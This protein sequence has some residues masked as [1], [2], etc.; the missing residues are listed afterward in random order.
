MALIN[1]GEEKKANELFPNSPELFNDQ[2]IVKV[3][4]KNKQYDK[5]IAIYKELLLKN[6]EDM[7]TRSYLVATYMANNQNWLALQELRII[8][9]KSPQ[10]KDQIDALIKE[11]EEG[12]NPFN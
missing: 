2:K 5:V 9:E 3:Y 1:N 4:V 7:Q 10:I 12:R 8:K 6:P 11:I